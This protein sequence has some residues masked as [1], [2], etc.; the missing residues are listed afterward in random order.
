MFVFFNTLGGQ[1][2]AVGSFLMDED[3]MRFEWNEIGIQ[4]KGQLCLLEYTSDIMTR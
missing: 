1:R 2:V 4:W 3:P